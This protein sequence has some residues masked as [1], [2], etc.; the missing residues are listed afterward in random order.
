MKAL[1]LLLA[2]MVLF[3]QPVIQTELRN[4]V[5]RAVVLH[6][7]GDPVTD[8]SPARPGETLTIQG[9]GFAAAPQLLV[10]G[11]PA[12][13]TPLDDAN[14]QFTLAP[15]TGGGF[16]ELA[17][18]DGNAASVP[19]DG[20]ADAVQL[21]AAEVQTIVTHAALASDGPGIAIVVV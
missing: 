11:A 6:L 18:V 3:A 12:D 13:S 15:D 1:F 8:Q 16:L 19:V 14:L 21:T 7:S 2:P 5:V 17:I 20:P 9:S 4:G 10:G